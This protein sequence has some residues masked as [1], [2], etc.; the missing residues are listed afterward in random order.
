M[1]TW[2]FGLPTAKTLVVRENTAHPALEHWASPSIKWIDTVNFRNLTSIDYKWCTYKTIP[3]GRAA[4]K[5]SGTASQLEKVRFTWYPGG[6]PTD[7]LDIGIAG[8]WGTRHTLRKLTVLPDMCYGGPLRLWS[9]A[10]FDGFTALEIL[11]I[12]A[13]AFF[14]E[15]SF[16]G[17]KDSP[18]RARFEHWEDI[19][20]LLPPNVHELEL[21]FKY[22][23]GIFATGGSKMRQF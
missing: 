2:L 18:N 21:W 11:R 6:A 16:G 22:P 9:P 3:Y 5:R 1:S 15:E 20:P 17:L 8:L 10:R 13:L 23:S 14:Q 4:V 7:G 19:T 12:P